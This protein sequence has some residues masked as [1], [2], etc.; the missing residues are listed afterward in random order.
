MNPI[1]YAIPV[2]MASILLEVVI[3]RWKRVPT[4]DIPD[5]LTSLHFGTLSQTIGAFVKVLGFGL[6][7]AVYDRWR[8]LE[9]PTDAWWVWVAALVVYDFIYYWIHRFG[10]EVNCLWAAHQVHHSSEY[11][12]LSTALRQS[13]TGAVVGWPFYLVMAVAGVPPLVFGVVALIDLLYQYWVHTELVRKLG[14]FDR[15][16]V[17]PSNHRV[18]HGQNDYCIDRNYGGILII[19]DRLFGTFQEERDEEP[20]VYGIRKPLRSFN[21]V[22]GNLHVWQELFAGS[23]QA[24]R[25]GDVR[26]AVAIF[27]APPAGW[28]QHVEHL[29]PASVQRFDTGTSRT[30]RRYALVQYA[31]MSLYATHFI[32]VAPALSL[33]TRALYAGV[34]AAGAVSAGWLLEGRKFA[35]PVEALRLLVLGGAFLLLPNWFG[36]APT[37]QVKLAVVALLATSL[38]WLALGLVKVPEESRASSAPL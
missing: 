16:F 18:H 7:V 4:Y 2:F 30:V 36:W 28:G 13:S 6:Y 17:S 5:A 14:W 33:G 32:A 19:W 25:R 38:V 20:V 11:Y 9:L 23:W 26:G 35:L 22:W 31:V 24:L 27:F 3:A 34:I 12:N 10:H 8:A 21:A 15:V 37:Q 1:V 29:D